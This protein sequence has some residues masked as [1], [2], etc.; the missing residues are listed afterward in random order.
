[1]GNADYK[2]VLAL[3]F[4]TQYFS[5]LKRILFSSREL[6][7]KELVNKNDLFLIYID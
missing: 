7:S 2:S 6:R 5:L 4:G 3:V 1:M